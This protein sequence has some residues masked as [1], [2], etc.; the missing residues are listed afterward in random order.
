M[1]TSGDLEK[2]EAAC[3][4]IAGKAVLAVRLRANLTIGE[5]A[6]MLDMRVSE[7]SDIEHGRKTIQQ[8]ILDRQREGK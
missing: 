2:V 3:R 1:P 7:V 6:E 4:E 5:F 8:V